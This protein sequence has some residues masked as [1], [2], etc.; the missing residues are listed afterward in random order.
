MA[1]IDSTPGA[2]VVVV[3]GVRELLSESLTQFGFGCTEAASG[4][5]A[6]DWLAWENFDLIVPDIRMAD[7]NGFEVLQQ[8]RNEHLGMAVLMVSGLTSPEAF[9]K[10]KTLGADVFLMKPFTLSQLGAAIRNAYDER[11]RGLADQPREDLDQPLPG[12]RYRFT[13]EG[14]ERCARPSWHLRPIPRRQGHLYGQRLRRPGVSA[15]QPTRTL[16]R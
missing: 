14:G 6:L 7:M 9:S 10:S 2:L 5:E 12:R 1:I 16:P 3:P 13:V 11:D 4:E 8:T 15:H